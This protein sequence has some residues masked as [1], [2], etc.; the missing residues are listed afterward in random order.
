MR[1]LKEERGQALI[2][3][4]VSVG[5]FIVLLIGA[6]EFG[7]L[8]FAA[9][10]VTDAAEAAA[11]YATQ[12]PATAANATAMLSAAKGDFYSPSELT[13]STPTYACNC[14]GST[15]SVSCTN[16][17][18]SNPTCAGSAYVEVTITVQTQATYTPSIHLPGVSSSFKLTGTAKRKVLQ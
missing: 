16:N 14:V 2:E 13:M 4:A 5:L 17:D 11:Q 8:A 9:T 15:T 18:P 10:Q 12:S 7:Q 3:T 6:V 1:L